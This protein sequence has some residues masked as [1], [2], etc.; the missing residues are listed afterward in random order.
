PTIR[1]IAR[2][3]GFSST[4]T[5]R[6]YLAALEKKGYLKRTNN[7]SRAI[8]LLQNTFNKIPI[9]STIAAGKPSFAYEDIEGYVDTDDLFLG[10]LTFDDIFALKVKGESMI[11]AGIMDGDIA[12]IKKQPAADNGD[13]IAALLENN[14]V[15]LKRLRRKEQ[16]IYLEAA[17]PDYQ[18]IYKD[19]TVMGK[20]ITIVRKYT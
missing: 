8:E 5:V 11:E 20:L 1:E 16:T 7:K 12:V 2:E 18:P 3:S 9:I 6:D 14:E 10:R 4:G 17:N 19:F 15:T 13:I